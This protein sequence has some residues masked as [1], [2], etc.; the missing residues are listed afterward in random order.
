MTAIRRQ[1]PGRQLSHHKSTVLTTN[2]AFADWGEVFPNAVCV[3]S[4][5]DRL[6]HSAEVV[7]IEGEPT[8]PRSGKHC[9]RPSGQPRP[10]RHA[11]AGPPDER[12]PVLIGAGEATGSNRA[13]RT[14]ALDSRA[15][16]DG[17]AVFDCLQAVRQALWAT[18]GPQVQQQAWREQLI[19]HG[20]PPALGPDEPF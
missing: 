8:R 4:L 12:Q 13:S 9:A 17:L 2:H 11:H 6:M 15:G 20:Q 7:H 1:A 14:T 16:A 3:V 19:P 18:Y 5:I 10:R